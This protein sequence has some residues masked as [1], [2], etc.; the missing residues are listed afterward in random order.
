MQS[1][2]KPKYSRKCAVLNCNVK[3]N[4]VPTRKFF[5]FPV[6]D[7]EKR[8]L[9][10]SAINRKNEDGTLWHP[11]K[12]DSICSDHFQSGLHS[13]SR[14][15]TD[16]CPSMFPGTGGKLVKIPPPLQESRTS[17][18]PGKMETIL[19]DHGLYYSKLYLTFTFY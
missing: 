10:I 11:R 12:D 7:K 19:F 9:W 2:K 4:S 16:Y 13:A 1:S 18:K 15:D 3:N 6:R 17:K 14:Y 8:K 5:R